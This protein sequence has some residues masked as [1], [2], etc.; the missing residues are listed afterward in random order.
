MRAVISKV[1]K[2]KK[3]K[4]FFVLRLITSILVNPM[5]EKEWKINIQHQE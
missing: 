5:K 3:L 1:I 4:G 2:S